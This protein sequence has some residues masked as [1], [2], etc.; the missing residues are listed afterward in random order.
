[1][2]SL[3]ICIVCCSICMIAVLVGVM[4]GWCMSLQCPALLSY[5][6]WRRRSTRRTRASQRRVRLVQVSRGCEVALG[7]ASEPFCSSMSMCRSLL[8]DSF[9]FRLFAFARHV[10][11]QSLFRIIDLAAVT[12]TTHVTPS[13]ALSNYKSAAAIILCRGQ[14]YTLIQRHAFF[15]K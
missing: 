12:T 13:P 8:H 2:L 6:P 7:N 3:R 15:H 10:V 11:S 1:V 5:V 4:A 9:L 14:R